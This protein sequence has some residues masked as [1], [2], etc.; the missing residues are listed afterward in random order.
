MKACAIAVSVA[1]HGLA[2]AAVVQWQ[3]SGGGGSAAGTTGDART[4]ESLVIETSPP[5]PEPPAPELA[6]LALP[7][8][9]IPTT[10]VE[11]PPAFT[12]PEP[13][14]THPAVAKKVAPRHATRGGSTGAGRGEGSGVAFS[15]PSYRDCPAPAYP[16]SA[17]AARLAG[18]VVLRVGIGESG[19]VESVVV[20]RSSG[21][22]LLDTAA[23]RAVRG[24]R[25]APA[26]RDGRPVAATAEVPVRFALSVP[27]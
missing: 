17:R 11:A 10:H 21:H 14:P 16:A 9:P 15:P 6:E 7:P 8:L 26:R 5:A 24:W 1:L 12:A 22:A 3:I 27:A 25:F 2:L 4:V 20:A 23:V 19:A 13:V 18:T